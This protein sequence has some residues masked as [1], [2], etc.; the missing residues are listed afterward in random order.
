LPQLPTISIAGLNA[1]EPADPL[2]DVLDAAGNRLC[3]SNPLRVAADAPRQP[4][5]CDLRTLP[6]SAVRAC[7]LGGRLWG[8][9]DQFPPPSPSGRCRLVE[10]TFAGMGGK[11]EDAPKTAVA[12]RGET[13]GRYPLVERCRL[14]SHGLPG[15]LAGTWLSQ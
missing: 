13:D 8:H 10:P 1:R 14:G 12:E 7:Y 4:Y 6:A 15:Y 5:W 11:E 3:S 2:V 9:E